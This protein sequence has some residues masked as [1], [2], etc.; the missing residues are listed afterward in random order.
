MTQ[1][2]FDIDGAVEVDDGTEFDIGGVVERDTEA[3][4]QTLTNNNVINGLKT[5]KPFLSGNMR[6][7]LPGWAN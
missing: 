4:E 5:K 2:E 3:G 7:R 6:L 1:N